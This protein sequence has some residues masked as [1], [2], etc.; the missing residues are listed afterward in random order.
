LC[1]RQP[2]NIGLNMRNT[3]CIML[4]F[5]LV[6]L[7]YQQGYKEGGIKD[8]SSNELI[9]TNE[10]IRSIFDEYSGDRAYLVSDYIKRTEYAIKAQRP[11]VVKCVEGMRRTNGYKG[12]GD[13]ASYNWC[14]WMKLGLF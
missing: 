4:V 14:H 7:S 5:F 8:K 3:L 13:Y 2:I 6:F 1:K 9:I 10:I 12:M 11:M